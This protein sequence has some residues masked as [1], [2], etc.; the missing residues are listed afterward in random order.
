MGPRL[1][2]LLL[3]LAGEAIA[4][5]PHA[6]G[7]RV[8]GGAS[9]EVFDLTVGDKKGV[10]KVHRRDTGPARA[11]LA[12]QLGDYKIAAERYN[13]PKILADGLV[14]VRL[15]DGRVTVG[16]FMERVDGIRLDQAINLYN[17]GKSPR[18]GV[19][20]V[21]RAAGFPITEQHLKAFYNLQERL[22][23][24]RQ[25]LVDFNAENIILV[26]ADKGYLRVID[27][28]IEDVPKGVAGDRIIE[29]ALSYNRFQLDMVA[30]TGP[31]AQTW[32]CAFRMGEL[33]RNTGI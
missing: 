25:S 32:S 2:L 14:E 33:V 6:T 1:T 13:G 22:M 17:V 19:E 15:P 11:E 3:I 10:V 29:K 26:P 5:D 9:G 30:A 23:R 31:G 21:A 16:I 24:H 27:P 7:A 8:G 12:E 28:T 4:A 20:A 18:E